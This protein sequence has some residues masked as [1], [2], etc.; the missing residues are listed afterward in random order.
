M[1]ITHLGARSESGEAKPI[2]EY[3]GEKLTF[4]VVYF[5]LCSGRLPEPCG[6][7]QAVSLDK[8]SYG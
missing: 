4:A 7:L 5:R 6:T 2:E 8:F 3:H 1:S